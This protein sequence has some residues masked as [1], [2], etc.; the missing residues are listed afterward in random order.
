MASDCPEGEISDTGYSLEEEIVY[1]DEVRRLR[2]LIQSLSYDE[3]RIV[4]M[5]YALGMIFKD[6]GLRRCAFRLQLHEK[7]AYRTIKETLVPKY[8]AYEMN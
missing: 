6:I 5:H 8:I 1:G 2:T 4:Q 7:R 3:K